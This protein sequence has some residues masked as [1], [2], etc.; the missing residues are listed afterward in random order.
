M[1]KVNFRWIIAMIGLMILISNYTTWKKKTHF[2]ENI[3][4]TS[5][6][7]DNEIISPGI[8]SQNTDTWGY[9]CLSPS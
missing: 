4:G 2:V 1:L 9:V 8:V 3:F 5:L 6:Q 7:I